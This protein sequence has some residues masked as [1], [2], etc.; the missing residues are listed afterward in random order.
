MKMNT[1]KSKTVMSSGTSRRKQNPVTNSS[2]TK[3]SKKVKMNIDPT[4]VLAISMRPDNLTDLVG[5]DCV[6]KSIENQMD[7]GRIPHFYLITGP[8]GSGKTTLA[9]IISRNLLKCTDIKEINAA[10][11]NGVDD[12]RHLVE[13]MKYMPVYPSKNKVVILDEAH[14]LTNSAQNALITE[15]EDVA[16]YVY[17]IFCTSNVTKIIPALKR[18]AFV[19]TPQPLSGKEIENLIDKASS[20]IALRNTDHNV[21]SLDTVELKK[22]LCEADITSPG[23]V[24]QA[25]ERFYSGLPI[26]ASVSFVDDSKIDVME[27]CRALGAGKWSSCQKMLKSGSKN[28]VP[29][30]RNCALGYLKS[31]LLN[32]SNLTTSIKLAKAITHLSVDSIRVDEASS[33]PLFASSV[34]LTCN[35]LR[36]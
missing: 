29:A 36:P 3:D 19:I 21:S 13:N 24:L 12:I 31:M 9:R 4:R 14:Q 17:Y 11:K 26:S 27:F 15:T 7:S 30:L 18:R 5:Q 23:L 35:E 34:C 16:D 25:V 2:N 6:V 20:V 32:S 10:N 1:T 28:D 8:V 33:F 22:A